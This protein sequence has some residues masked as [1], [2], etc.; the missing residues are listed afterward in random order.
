MSQCFMRR[1]IDETIRAGGMRDKP[2]IARVYFDPRA[3]FG[4]Q[5]F[6][7]GVRLNRGTNLGIQKSA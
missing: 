3:V 2:H 5:R 6:R 1:F 4:I 7:P